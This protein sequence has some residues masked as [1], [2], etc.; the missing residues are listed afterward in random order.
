MSQR[1]SSSYEHAL[2]AV[3]WD[4]SIRGI[5][6]DPVARA[7]ALA[8]V[9]AEIARNLAVCTNQWNCTIFMGADNAP[10]DEDELED[11]CNINATQG[12]R[13]L[14]K[15]LK[16]LGYEVPQITKKNEEG[17][18]ES[19]YSAGE[20]AIQKMLSTNQFKYPGGDPA[21]RAILKIRELGKLKSSY[22]NAKLLRRAGEAYFISLYN[23]AGTLSGRRNSKKHPFGFG[24]NGQNFPKR[25]KTAKL[26]RRCLVV[27]VGY[28]FLFVDQIQAEDWPVSALAGNMTALQDLRAGVDRHSKLASIIYRHRVPAK[29]DPDWDEALYEQERYIGKKARHANN[30]DMRPPRLQDEL[31]QEAS[32]SVSLAACKQILDDVHRADPSVKDVF[33]KQI[34]ET[35]SRDRVLITPSPFFR[36]RQFLGL[37]PTDTNSATLKEAYSFIPQSTVADNTGYAVLELESSGTGNPSFI[38]QEGHDS[39]TQEVV[40][41]ELEV[42]NTLLRTEAAFDRVIRFHNG[43]EIK[44]P[45]EA[46]VGYSFAESVKIKEFSLQGVKAALEK[47]R[48][49]A[50][51]SNHTQVQ[52]PVAV[53]S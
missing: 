25:S 42:Y 16:D 45:L 51:K 32:L 14:L 30:Y 29:T 1:V 12:E 21:L 17:D 10:E 35:L 8:I 48:D 26:F 20:L 53:T 52:I 7:D 15:K 24:G 3:Y 47:L 36:E 13:A 40:D 34:Q 5:R 9:D 37:R 41:S 31:V 38:V 4:I 50:R 11:S 19:I 18:Y 33:H 43:I 46:E 22:L 39:I 49:L 44:I 27:R 23:V 6:I 28:V 2:Q